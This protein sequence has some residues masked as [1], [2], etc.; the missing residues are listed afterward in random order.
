MEQVAKGED[1]PGTV[2]DPE[3]DVNI[4]LP[5]Q[6]TSLYTLGM[7]RRVFEEE[8]AARKASGLFGIGGFLTVQAG[9]PD[10]LQKEYDEIAGVGQTPPA[11][12]D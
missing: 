5:L 4:R 7:P 2:S 12:V 3:A 11:D 10:H 6:D 1:P 8:L 9:R